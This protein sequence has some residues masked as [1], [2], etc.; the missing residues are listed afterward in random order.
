MQFIP[1]G[2]DIPEALLQR[3]E[4]GR[5]LFFCGAGISCPAGLPLFSALIEAL[6]AAFG[7]PLNALELGLF[8]E[9]HLD[10]VIGRYE[11]RLQGGRPGVRKHL[12]SL[13][14][15][16]LTR[17]AALTT[18]RA[19]LELGRNRSGE[20]RLVTTNFDR[21]FEEADT[22]RRREPEART[23]HSSP[24]A[25][26]A[27]PRPPRGITVHPDPPVRSHW[28]GV[29][30][31]HGRLPEHPSSDDLDRLVIADS[32]FGRAYLTES[33]AARFVAGLLRDFTLCFVGYSIE[34]PVMRYMTAAHA[35]DGEGVM[36]AFAPCC[37][38][39]ASKASVHKQ[40]QA[41]HVTPILYDNQNC[42]RLLHRT[43]H[44]WASLYRDKI[45]GKQR[46]VARY[47]R[48][49]PVESNEHNDFVGRLL[50]AL[51]DPS[52]QPAQRFAKLNPCPPLEWL[53]TFSERRFGHDDLPRFDVAPQ[54]QPHKTQ[55]FS[56]INRPA[57]HHRTAQMHLVAFGHQGGDWDP[58]MGWLAEWLLRHLDDPRLVLWIAQSG[59]HM[60]PRWQGLLGY[61]LRDLALLDRNGNVAELEA[62]R[63]QAPKAIP[64]PLM[65][66]LWRLVINGRLYVQGAEDELERW[67]FQLEEEGLNTTLRL[68]FRDL[69]APRVQLGPLWRWDE[70]PLPGSATELSQLVSWDLRLTSD[71]VTELFSCVE[72]HWQEALPLLV[73][74]I[75][76]LLQDSLDLHREIRL[77]DP[78][79]LQT[80]W[81]LRSIHDLS[82]KSSNDNHNWVNL[83][84]LLRDAWLA[85]HRQD[86][87][88]AS[89][90]AQSWA[91]N[92]EPTFQRLALFAASQSCL[93]A[94]QWVE[95]LL[96]D[97]ARWLWDAATEQELHQLLECQ[98][99]QLADEAQDLLEAAILAGPPPNRSDQPAIEQTERERWVWERLTNLNTSGL[100]IG[101]MAK[102]RLAELDPNF[103]TTP[104]PA[105][106]ACA[107]KDKQALISWLAHHRHQKSQPYRDDPWFRCCSKHPLHALVA[108]EALA[109]EGHWPASYWDTALVAFSR[110]RP[111]LIRRLWGFSAPVMQRMPDPAVHE[112]GRNLS[113][114]L[115]RVCSAGMRHY[116]ILFDLCC[117]L[118][119]LLPKD[120]RRTG[121]NPTD[122]FLV[123]NASNHPVGHITKTLLVLLFN[124][125]L[126]KGIGLPVKFQQAFS[127]LCL[128]SAVDYR[129]GRVLLACNLLRLFELDRDWTLT[130][131]IPRLNW[132]NPE[133]ASALWQG[134]TQALA[135]SS[136]HG[137][138]L[139]ETISG[140][141][142]NIDE[143]YNSL[144]G[145]IQSF[146]TFLT[147]IALGKPDILDSYRSAFKAMPITGLEVAA[148]TL[149][150]DLKNAERKEEFWQTR[151]RPF[152]E[153]WWPKSANRVSPQISRL[154]AQLVL[155]TGDEF[156]DAVDLLKDWL[157]KPKP[158]QPESLVRYLSKTDL[159]NR[160]PADALTFLDQVVDQNRPWRKSQ[161]SLRECLKDIAKAAPALANDPRFQ[162]LWV[163]APGVP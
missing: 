146:A 88:R 30:H 143:H 100:T 144:G 3:H 142:P 116:D 118:L 2:P 58:V 137:H 10:Q 37:A 1:N 76:Q 5:V 42:H 85:I 150:E 21:L 151:I 51:A 90:I 22:A 12:P 92:P 136:A 98:G 69:L 32:D 97:E 82:P 20:L 159:R 135:R 87:V 11:Q 65:R 17:P 162:A 119:P 41:K 4:E 67:L 78:N 133:E 129:H 127:I 28:E 29:V 77:S 19:L 115:P 93:P 103:P 8:H 31:L 81:L 89:C 27:R 75:Q 91:E 79:R 54:E 7:E 26:T 102:A 147:R 132:E 108:L 104:Q 63:Q 156:H 64:G 44:V 59:G 72:S 6:A 138:P 131:L 155:A 14:T 48:R 39:N 134:V 36:F 125:Q 52:G 107:P 145:G 23:S 47:A 96:A 73:A 16:V 13:L 49:P 57:P 38:A 46:L 70:D 99:D 55:P 105:K 86:V 95:W 60:H 33:W 80:Y 157:H 153:L 126:S 56:L 71:D 53:K 68:Q 35:L 62:L 61:K 109:E 45:R 120:S 50:W 123:N 101:D 148:K 94:V 74:D 9:G 34:D 43:L 111:I 158:D 113:L 163:H 40:W 24:R 139:L 141:L 66:V 161:T 25:N 160:F 128:E 83:I 18:H 149:V 140:M 121:T 152:W 122:G 15:P 117:R 112:I 106:Q 114:L 130:I 154:L 110:K 124:G 84:L